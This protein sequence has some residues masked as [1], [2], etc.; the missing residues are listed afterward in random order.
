MIPAAR[1][2]VGIV[3]AGRVGSVLGAALA[4]A[5][6][7]L[8]AASTT[9]P[10]RV[11]A[12]LPGLQ[13]LDELSVLAVSQLVLLTVPTAVLPEVVAGAA[14][15]GAFVPGQL[16]VHT[17][18]R[19]GTSVLDPAAAAGA[20]PLALHPALVFTGT[21][22][23]LHALTGA[24]MAVTAPPT[25]QPIGQ[26]LVIEMGAEPVLVSEQDRPVY[27]QAIESV[28]SLSTKVVADAAAELR[29][30]GMMDPARVLREVAWSAVTLALREGTQ[31]GA[32]GPAQEE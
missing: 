28:R 11:Q 31:N 4:G 18:A 19:Y 10:D 16:V 24:T 23:D 22:V 12:M 8:I 27:A 29:G 3:G 21:S 30:I 13:I 25:V 17:A 32:E 9:D 14:A 26:A 6:H 20:I 15:A 1:L 2:D 7:R 5:G